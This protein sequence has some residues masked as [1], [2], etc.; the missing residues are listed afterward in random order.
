MTKGNDK[1]HINENEDAKRPD[2][3]PKPTKYEFFIFFIFF[4]FLAGSIPFQSP[5]NSLSP[6]SRSKASCHIIQNVTPPDIKD[7]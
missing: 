7:I 4:H 5:Q 1:I 3:R 2:S 6:C